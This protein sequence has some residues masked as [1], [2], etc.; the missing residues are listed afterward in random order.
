MTLKQ[1]ADSIFSFGAVPLS[2]VRVGITGGAA[3]LLL[4]IFLPVRF[5]RM[6]TQANDESIKSE[7][8]KTHSI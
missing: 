3:V 6:R 5:K 4:R 2:P 8:N 7:K 1:I